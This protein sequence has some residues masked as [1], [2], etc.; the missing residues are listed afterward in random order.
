MNSRSIG[1]NV[2]MY[3]AWLLGCLG[4]CSCFAFFFGFLHS[5]CTTLTYAMLLGLR[6]FWIITV[7]MQIRLSASR[8]PLLLD[9]VNQPSCI[10][11]GASDLLY[12][13]C[14]A[15][16]Y[17]CLMLIPYLDACLALSILGSCLCWFHSVL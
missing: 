13:L 6:F 17:V 4:R 2:C 3:A 16:V 5:G 1:S 9:L 7:C 12:C 14:Y 10:S 8:M 15:Y 11:A